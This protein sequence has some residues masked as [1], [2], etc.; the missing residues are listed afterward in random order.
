VVLTERD[1]DQG[2]RVRLSLGEVGGI[3]DWER[4]VVGE[5]KEGEGRAA[6]AAAAGR[7]EMVFATS[8]T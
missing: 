7:G 6:A 3:R 2:R 4:K 1:P 5:G 8:S